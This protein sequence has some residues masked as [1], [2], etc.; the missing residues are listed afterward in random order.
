MS[1]RGSCAGNAVFYHRKA[2]FESKI[3]RERLCFTIETA[4]GGREGRRCWT[5]GAAMVAYARLWSDRGAIGQTHCNG[6]FQVGLGCPWWR[7]VIRKCHCRW[8]NAL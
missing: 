8:S 5:A 1:I 7:C 6:G 4:V 3:A 2:A